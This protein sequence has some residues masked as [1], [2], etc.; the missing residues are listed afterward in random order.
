MQEGSMDIKGGERNIR[1]ENEETQVE[2][3]GHRGWS[4]SEITHDNYASIM[5]SCIQQQSHQIPA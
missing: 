3:I 1:R 4:P 5:G 2:I